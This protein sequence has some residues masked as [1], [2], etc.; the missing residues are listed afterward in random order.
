[1]RRRSLG[2]GNS[3]VRNKGWEAVDC[4][5]A[6][7]GKQWAAESKGQRVGISGLLRA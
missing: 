5:D 4:R 7:G 6:K 2:T 1:V 3:N